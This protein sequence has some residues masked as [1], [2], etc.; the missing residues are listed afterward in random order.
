MKK[1]FVPYELAL[2]LKELGFEEDC[3][4][5]WYQ[6]GTLNN[7]VP[8]Y[9]FQN[10]YK[11]NGYLNAPLWQQAFDW[12][13]REHNLECAII[14][15]ISSGYKLIERVYNVVYYKFELNTNVQT[16]ILRNEEGKIVR[17]NKKESARQ[18]CLEKLIELIKK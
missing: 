15:E 5:F 7:S 9:G 8:I 12:F 4:N 1:Q 13:L 6:S 11:T 2:K 17:F 10:W 3:I 18:T 16:H 14:P